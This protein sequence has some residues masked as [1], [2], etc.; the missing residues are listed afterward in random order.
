MYRNIFVIGVLAFSSA[1]SAGGGVA[2]DELE[3]MKGDWTLVSTEGNGKKRTA[4]DFKECSRKVTGASYSVTIET[5]EG[6][7]NIGIK[8]VK[9]DSSKSPK[10]IDVEMADGAAK[11]KIFRGIYKFENDTQV[12]CLAAPDKDRPGKF[13]PKEGTVTVWKRVKAKEKK[14]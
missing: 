14:V 1:I 5:E 7:Q 11:G 3:K 6:V 13:D 8:I 9:L 4:D 10:T 2:K 12:I